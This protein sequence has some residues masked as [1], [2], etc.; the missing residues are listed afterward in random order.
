MAK[1]IAQRLAFR[2]GLDEC[3]FDSA[4]LETQAPEQPTL[5]AATF[6]RGEKYHIATH[7]SKP[8]TASLADSADVIFCMTNDIV[9]AARKRFSDDRL[10]EKMILLNDGVMLNTK[11]KDIESPA[12][13]SMRSHRQVYAS[14][15]AAVG[16]MMRYLEDRD[17]SPETFGVKAVPKKYAGDPGSHKPFRLDHKT[18]V[19]LVNLLF[20]CIERSFEPPTTVLLHDMLAE[21][22]HQMPFSLVEDLLRVDL[23]GYVKR[24]VEGVWHPTS[25]AAARRRE[26][27][28]REAKY[29]TQEEEK[30]QR[31]EKVRQEEK[32]MTMALAVEV[33][34][35][36]DGFTFDDAKKRY[37]AL[38][39]R[40]HPDKFHD[41]DEFRSM[42]EEKARRVNLAW[43]VLEKTMRK[44][45]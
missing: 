23:N 36:K 29:R 9:K 34:G 44:R 6:M 22:G 41:D 2:D 5:A 19:F 31:R 16:R 39:S 14:L 15:L 28:R 25:G 10:A 27:A 42:A 18:R 20:D 21:K 30:K 3:S 1:A 8:L 4:G 11:R 33:L 7:V 35:L 17:M 24:D 37:R 12:A 43:G 13:N 40:Y 32:T 26:E 38:L 45:S